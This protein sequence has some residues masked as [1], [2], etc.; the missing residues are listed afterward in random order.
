MVIDLS[1]L[2]VVWATAMPPILY[3]YRLVLLFRFFTACAA[4]RLAFFVA[5]RPEQAPSLPLVN[6]HF[7]DQITSI[8][9]L[10]PGFF[11]NALLAAPWL[12]YIV[13][14]WWN[15]LYVK[16]SSMILIIAATLFVFSDGLGHRCYQNFRQRWLLRLCVRVVPPSRRNGGELVV[17]QII[18][19]RSSW[20]VVS[21]RISH[22]RCES[23]LYHFKFE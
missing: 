3:I 2:H 15:P 16:L 17:G 5:E 23:V 9:R 13:I 10:E 14:F 11:T 12:A 22:Q 1:L 21:T 18:I 7:F 20:R 8:T 19:N 6:D 4:L